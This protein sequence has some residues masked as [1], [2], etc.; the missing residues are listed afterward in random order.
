MFGR[1]DRILTAQM[2]RK[3]VETVNAGSPAIYGAYKGPYSQ[4]S[5]RARIEALFLDDIGKILTREQ[6]I[7]AAT[8]PI[9]GEAPENWHQR[10]SELR[11]DHGYT[12]LSWRDRGDLKVQE[13]LMPYVDKRAGVSRRVKPTAETWKIVL[14]RGNY[15]CEWDEGGIQCGLAEGEI[16]PVGGGTVRLTADHKRPHSMNP[17][18]DPNDPDQWQALCGRHQVI[19]K[20][21]WDS[22]SGKLNAYA[23]VQAASKDE[24]AVIFDFLLE[25]F[26]YIRLEG[27][28]IE[29]RK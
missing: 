8:D 27:G 13:Y 6:I 25:H 9:T 11:V 19:K 17:A 26:G 18:S 24:K 12:I 3:R 20:N 2:G 5:V 14:K 21:F 29:K 22:Q 23:I 28:R 1:T 15:R 7:Q 4:K 16:D 10:L